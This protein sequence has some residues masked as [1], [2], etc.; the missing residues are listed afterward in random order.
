[1]PASCS[2]RVRCDVEIEHVRAGHRSP[3]APGQ[4]PA[5]R[6]DPA[7]WSCPVPVPP[8][9]GMLSPMRLGDPPLLVLIEDC[10]GLDRSSPSRL[11]LSYRQ[12]GVSTPH[13]CDDLALMPRSGCPKEPCAAA[14]VPTTGAATGLLVRERPTLGSHG[15]A[16]VAP[17][18]A[19]LQPEP[20]IGR[21]ELAVDACHSVLGAVV[22]VDQPL[23]T[24]GRVIEQEDIVARAEHGVAELEFRGRT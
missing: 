23:S 9:A 16:A 17:R 2:A 22:D 13:P 3:H 7:A 11:S 6:G 5:L 4:E 20:R 21:G 14:Q 19:A 24:V 15:G 8:E 1:M 18:D 10:V 12:M